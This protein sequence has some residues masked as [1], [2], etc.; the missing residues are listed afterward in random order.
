MV[1][2]TFQGVPGVLRR[3][4]G[5]FKAIPAC[6]GGNLRSQ[7]IPKDLEVFLGASVALHARGFIESH[8]RFKGFQGASGSGGLTDASGSLR[9]APESARWFYGISRAI[10]GVSGGF[11]DSQIVHQGFF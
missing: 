7:R 10:Q 11:R 4:P 2:R 8:G 6:V 5:G 1:S 3:V 9:S